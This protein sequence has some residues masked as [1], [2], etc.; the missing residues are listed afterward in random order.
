MAGYVFISYVREDD[1]LVD[2]LVRD[3]REYGVEVW[4]DRD[5]LLPGQRWRDSIRRAIREGALFLACFSHSYEMRE[6]SYMNEELS[7]AIHELRS[8]PYDRQWFVPVL[9]TPANIPAIPLGGGET[10]RD[11]QWLDL[12][13]DWQAG[14]QA[15]VAA[16]K[17]VLSPRVEVADVTADA[18]PVI[19]GTIVQ[20]AVR[21]ETSP[22]APPPQYF[23]CFLSY[24]S[25]DERFAMQLYRDMRSYG[26]RCWFAPEDLKIG[27]VIRESVDEAIRKHDRLL[28]VLSTT[29]VRSQWV[30]QEVERALQEERDR[31]RSILFPVRIDNS[32]F[33]VTAG[34]ALF[35][36]N[37][38]H[39]GDFCGWEARD[40]YIMS[41]ERLLRDLTVPTS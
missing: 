22:A 24:S 29:S 26:V 36:R 23:S 10:L 14:L 13:A 11:L 3:L 12:S 41:L 39:I 37:S 21:P 33:D 18:A 32:V 35:I 40:I 30:E 7:L 38:R 15:L 28:V 9:L 19:I 16:A 2:R 20:G 8:R 1:E 17:V 25:K 6:R 27:A 34:W 4:L 31:Q 5:K